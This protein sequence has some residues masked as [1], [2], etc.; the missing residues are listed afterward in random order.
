MVALRD[1][2]EHLYSAVAYRGAIEAEPIARFRSSGFLRHW[3]PE[4]KSARVISTVTIYA[5][6]TK[7]P[8]KIPGQIDILFCSSTAVKSQERT[9]SRKI[10]RTRELRR[11]GLL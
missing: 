11:T 2:L 9:F 6:R 8:M 5:S 4:R 7:Q 3:Q 1:I 10:E